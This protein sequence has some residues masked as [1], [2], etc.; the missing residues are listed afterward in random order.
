M[1]DKTF[2]IDATVQSQYAASSHMRLLVD[3]FWKSLNPEAD[4]KSIYDNMVN[5]DT[6]VGFG[7]DVWGRIVAIGREYVAIDENTK[8]LGFAPSPGINNPRLDTFNQAPFYKQI[9]GK[10]RLT[11]NAYRVYI[12][13]K[14]L[15]NISDGTLASINDMLKTMFPETQIMCI[16]VDTMTLRLVIQDYMSES[17]KTALLNLPWLPA[18]VGLQMYQVVT[19]TFGFN[20]SGLHPFNCGTFAAYGIIIN[21]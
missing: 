20:G 9:D 7:L 6:A 4:I 8:Y 11:D 13:L 1:A 5:L 17:D 14:A 10:V 2:Y 15:I 21:S 18:G 19:P 12:L 16:H 3:S